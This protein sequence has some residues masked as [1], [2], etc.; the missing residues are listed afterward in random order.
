MAKDAKEVTAPKSE[1][2]LDAI[3]TRIRKIESFLSDFGLAIDIDGDGKVGKASIALLVSIFI[4][5]TVGLGFGRDWINYTVNEGA[6]AGT[7]TWGTDD[8]GTSTLVTDASTISNQTINGTVTLQNGETIDNA[9]DADVRITYDDD[10]AILGEVVLE[11]D[12]AAANIV[13]ND[14]F[15]IRAK[16]FP[17][18]S[19]AKV[20]IGQAKF[21]FTDVTSNSVDGSFVISPNV[22]GT[23]TDMVTVDAAGVTLENGA[24][25]ANPNADTVT[26]TEANIMLV[27]AVDVSGALNADGA[28]TFTANATVTGDLIQQTGNIQAIQ[29]NDTTVAD[30]AI[31]PNDVSSTWVIDASGQAVATITNTI[32]A[33]DAAGLWVVLINGGV[34]N[35]VKITEGT[36]LDSGGDKTLGPEDVMLLFSPSAASWSA[37][38][39]DN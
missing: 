30:A 38:Y 32:L 20:D 39:H 18:N 34:S 15:V 9:T 14:S 37:I 19:T 22:A 27:G 12:N 5:A 17:S 29:F 6:N 13:D 31:D 8:A 28:A 11:S 24:V 16:A 35:S 10:A 1:K 2:K 3:A 23:I 36:T 7:A 33:P 21:V 4:V 25:V 26:V